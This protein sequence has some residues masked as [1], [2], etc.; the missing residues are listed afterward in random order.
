MRS[1]CHS[2]LEAK[3]LISRRV[4][5]S[6][7]SWAG[8]HPFGGISP[9]PAM[10]LALLDLFPLQGRAAM[11][12]PSPGPA[13]LL[14]ASETSRTESDKALSALAFVSSVVPVFH[15]RTPPSA[16]SRSKL[17]CGF[18]TGPSHRPFSSSG[19]SLLIG[20]CFW[21]VSASSF[22]SVLSSERLGAEQLQYR[23]ALHLGSNVDVPKGKPFV[24]ASVTFCAA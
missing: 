8:K 17:K 23:R 4:C 5:A 1:A 10:S 11:F 18:S 13:L 22:A 2:K 20:G 12:L 15:G 21:A 7:G 9:C 14:S 19:R 24:G 16:N 6:C 3:K